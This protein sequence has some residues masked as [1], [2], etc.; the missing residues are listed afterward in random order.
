MLTHSS[1]SVTFSLLLL[2]LRVFFLGAEISLKVCVNP[3]KAAAE[4]QKQ[5]ITNVFVGQQRSCS[6][7]SCCQKAK[8]QSRSLMFLSLSAQTDSQTLCF[9]HKQAHHELTQPLIFVRA[10]NVDSS[11]SGNSAPRSA[12]FPPPLFRTS[13]I[14]EEHVAFSLY[15]GLDKNRQQCIICRRKF[16]ASVKKNLLFQKEGKRFS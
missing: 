6:L 5:K 12:P 7:F 9:H 1:T 4:A 16:A 8:E 11:A 15:M 14:R 2:L 3:V 10:A 13:E